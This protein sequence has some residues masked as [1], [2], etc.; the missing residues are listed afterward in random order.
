M[1]DDRLGQRI[2]GRVLAGAGHVGDGKPVA[3]QEIPRILNILI[4]VSGFQA[5]SALGALV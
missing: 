5:F 4:F 3:A 1:E 2:R